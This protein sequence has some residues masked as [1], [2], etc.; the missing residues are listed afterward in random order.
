MKSFE[1]IISYVFVIL[2]V[3]IPTHAASENIDVTVY[4]LEDY[5][6]YSYIKDGEIDGA[7]TAI[8]KQVFSRMHGYNITIKPV[9]WVRGLK[10]LESGLG[11]AMYPMYHRFKRRSYV[12]PYSMALMNEKVAIFCTEDIYRHGPRPNWPD[13]YFGLTIGNNYGYA[14]GDDI[15]W[16][17]VKKGKIVVDETK[18]TQQNL[19]KLIRKRIDCYMSEKSTFL[20]ELNLLTQKKL[21]NDK[22][23]GRLVE[24]ATISYE[25]VFLG[26]TDND[27]GRFSYKKDFHQQ[28]DTI[29]YHMRHTGEIERIIKPYME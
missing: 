29:L 3:I 13:D 8:L 16:A 25:Q 18:T 15:F 12:W 17:A 5:P 14:Y 2:T 9:P 26:F 10:Y 23:D 20:W 1:T 24:G 19:L 4:A 7:H 6:P 21:Y 11:F 28:L 27:Q 22:V